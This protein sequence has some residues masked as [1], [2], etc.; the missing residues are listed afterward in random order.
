MLHVFNSMTRK[1]EPFVPLQEGKVFMYVCGPTVYDHSHIGH[2]RAY[3]S[4]DMVYRHLQFLGYQVTYVRN[5]TDVDDK[6]IHGAQRLGTTLDDF[7]QT[8]IQSFHEDMKA[9]GILSPGVQPRA[10]QTIP[11]MIEMIR[12]LVEQGQAYASG[13]DV[14]FSVRSWAAYG[15][16]SGRDIDDLKSG[17]RVEPGES[18]K[19]PLDF[20]LWKGSKEG[21]P[22]WDSP[23]GKGRPGWHIECSAMA[24]KYLGSS[25]DIHAGG[26]DLIFPH[27]ENEMA[28]SEACNQVPFAKYWLHNGFVN[29]SKEKM[30]KSLGN[31]VTIKDMLASFHPEAIRLFYLSSHYRSPIEYSQELIEQFSRA[32][33]RMYR[34]LLQ[35]R[36]GQPKENWK[37]HETVTSFVEAM[38]DDFNTPKALGAINDMIGKAYRLSLKQDQLDK[39]VEMASFAKSCANQLGLLAQDPEHYFQTIPGMDPDETQNIEKLIAEREYARREKNFVRADEIRASLAQQ[40]IVLEDSPEGTSWRKS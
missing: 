14:Y 3:T 6:I 5:L 18:K 40:G 29:L 30:S 10:T 36:P 25:I 21:E 26:R 38:N 8:Y 37:N 7:S 31:T 16:L 15:R 9:L 17:A 12:I 35:L 23:W 27:H 13:G 24:K 39:A 34:L 19:D 11:E 2:G 22:S 4:F 33:D 20:V 32:L 1:T 28:Q